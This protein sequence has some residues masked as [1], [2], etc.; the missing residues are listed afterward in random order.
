[1]L[2][3]A[4]LWL[5]LVTG[6]PL[7]PEHAGLL[8][9]LT[10]LAESM[11]IGQLGSDLADASFAVL[12]PADHRGLIEVLPSVQLDQYALST[13]H[14]TLQATLADQQLTGIVT[15]RRKSL[16]STW[17]K[18]QRK[19]HTADQIADRLATRVLVDDVEGCYAL[20][21]ALHG[22]FDHV[23]AEFD[24]YITNPKGNGYQSIHTVLVVPTPEGPLDV[25]VQLRTH[26]MHAAAEHGDA[27]HW[28][29]KRALAS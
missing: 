11:G 21:H 26:A 13:M 10:P 29:Y 17:S 12:Q 6:S 1:M 16:Y 2:A 7:A 28:A 20:L 9:E 22:R 14:S 25:E 3:D 5:A 4:I 19:G 23:P 18:M 8:P 27:A 15:S 24:D